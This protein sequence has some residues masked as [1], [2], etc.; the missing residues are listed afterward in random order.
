MPR[1]NNHKFYIAAQ[2]TYGQTP[3]GVHWLTQ[4]NQ[5][6]RFDAILSL[7]PHNLDAYSLA[8][9]GC[10]F[11]D[12]Y[13][14]L[15]AKPKSYVGIE[16]VPE[17]QEIAKKNTS[18]NIILADITKMALPVKDYYVCSGALNILT[19]FETHQFIANCYKAS[20]KGFIFNALHGKKESTTYNYLSKE[21]LSRIAKILQ[22][23]DVVYKQGY[24]PNDIT[25]GFLK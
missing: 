18:C 6:L 11:G 1:V 8:D 22:V 19:P 5:N 4:E 14:Y 21:T 12:F 25:V 10:G 24:L 2:Q 13:T 20:K 9:A 15:D 17:S 23:N 7:L 16:I 3:R